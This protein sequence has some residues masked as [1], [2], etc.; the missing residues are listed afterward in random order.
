MSGGGQTAGGQGF[1]ES[2]GGQRRDR[3]QLA[4]DALLRANNLVFLIQETI[5]PDSWFDTGTGNGT[6]TIYESKKLIVRQSRSVHNKI[7]KLLKEMRQS[8]GHQIAIEARFLVVGENFLEDIGLDVDITKPPVQQITTTYANPDVISGMGDPIRNPNYTGPWP[9]H[10]DPLVPPDPYNL[11][12]LTDGEP[13]IE[14]SAD[15]HRYVINNVLRE[16]YRQTIPGT[17][18]PT[19]TVSNTGNLNIQQS[20]AT[21]TIAPDSKITGSWATIVGEQPAMALSLS[22]MILDTLQV[23]LLLRATQAHRDAKSLT[24]PKVTVMSGESASLRVQRITGYP[25]NYQ[26][27][28][29]EIGTFGNYYW[30]VT[31][32]DRYLV[33]GTL[34]NITPTITPDKKNVLL[35][36]VAELRD[37]LGWTNYTINLPQVVGAGNLGTGW[38]IM[39]PETELSRVE[40]RVSVPDGGTLLL[41]GQK[42]T[43]ESE[44]ESGVPVLNKVPILGRLFSNKS[45]IKDEKILLILVRPTIVLQEEAEAEAIAAMEQQ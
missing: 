39:Y 38:T 45:K 4:Q 26:F 12:Y 8:L 18:T 13:E 24:A 19:T 33:T 10:P 23:D 16:P 1:Q 5:E 22:G 36:I 32:E 2:G 34:L 29:Q 44:L 27:N 37:F 17:G 9:Y 35:N 30:T 20:S 21:H 11:P 28:L 7:D 31:T 14:Y 42:V 25:T 40:T 43:A 41:G 6:I 3:T 15:L